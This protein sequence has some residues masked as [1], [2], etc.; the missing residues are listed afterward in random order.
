MDVSINNCP[1]CQSTKRELILDFNKSLQFIHNKYI[2]FRMSKYYCL[3]CGHIYSAEYNNS[4]L[5][6]HYKSTRDAKEGLIYNELED[7]DVT[8]IDLIEWMHIEGNIK[9]SSIKK[10]LDIGCGK[11][12]LLRTFSLKYNEAECFGIDYSTKSMEY[13]KGKGI[14]NIIVGDIYS[15][16]FGGH[17][18]DIISATGVLEHQIDI[19]T[20]MQKV[21]SLLNEHGLLI[22]QVPDSLSIL[23]GY[24]AE[25]SIFMHDICNEEHL[26][27]F[28]SDNL[29][30]YISNFG[31]EY[32]NHRS[33][34]RGMWE[35]TD[36]IMKKSGLNI[37]EQIIQKKVI[38]NG[39]KQFEEKRQYYKHKLINVLRKDGRIG[40]YGAGWHTTKVLSTFYEI[41]YDN[42]EVIFDQDP[43]KNGLQIYGV[44]IEFP[45]REK[46][47]E[48]DVIIISS[49]NVGGQ[50]KQYLL[51]CGFPDKNIVE[52]YD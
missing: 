1:I 4:L 35:I 41:E 30:K 18:F 31:Y 51:Q 11:C 43:R 21:S 48:M 6:D 7:L 14:E 2:S 36:I 9:S 37:S 34:M 19:S 12:D 15:E 46:V 45:E 25:K 20:F 32:V 5:E 10:I 17:K 47:L 27:H 8:F 39:I 40:L 50:I 38:D 22:I 26:H 42:I 49:I 24:K 28:D 3:F 13:G 23:N 33:K 52:L 44:N 29:I 16:S